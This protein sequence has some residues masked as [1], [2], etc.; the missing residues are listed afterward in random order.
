MTDI[1]AP[2]GS[3]ARFPDG[4]SDAD[5]TA[6]MR[7]SYPAPA[8]AQP[9]SATQPDGPSTPEEVSAGPVYNAGPSLKGAARALENNLPFAPEAV[10]G[11]QS[12][13][14]QGYGGT[15][16]GYDANLA[17]QRSQNAQY[18]AEN[19]GTDL[20]GAGVA[21]APALAASGMA[22]APY[23]ASAAGKILPLAAAILRH[24]VGP[25]VGGGIG[26]YALAEALRNFKP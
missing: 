8:P 19:P 5:I 2:D 6:V 9:A 10:A 3:I 7:R 23:A 26:G 20:A 15:G 25:A 16:Q 21:M 24:G 22:A 17:G 13:L 12:I 18:Q 1:Q 14:P 11:L 4:M